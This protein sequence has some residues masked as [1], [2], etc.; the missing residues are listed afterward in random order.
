MRKWALCNNGRMG[1]AIKITILEYVCIGLHLAQEG[2]DE[3]C[4]LQ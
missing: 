3:L 2:R 1:D 4:L